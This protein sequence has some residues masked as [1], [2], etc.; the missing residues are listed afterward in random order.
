MLLKM[1]GAGVTP[2]MSEGTLVGADT[3]HQMYVYVCKCCI[4]VYS[5]RYN[6]HNIHRSMHVYCIPDMRTCVYVRT[7]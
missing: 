6:I 1:W 5:S 3:K 2:T 4:H 7:C